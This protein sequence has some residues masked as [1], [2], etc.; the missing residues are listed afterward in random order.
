MR[1]GLKLW[2]NNEYYIQPAIDLYKRKLFDYIE[3]FVV[4]DSISYVEQWKELNIPFILHA[5][6]SMVGF[7][8]AVKE[9]ENSNFKLLNELERYREA[10][11]PQFI[12][13]HPGLDGDINET[14]R[15][16]NK[17][18][19][20]FHKIYNLALVENKPKIGLNGETCIA[21]MP[22]EIKR[23]LT[24]TDMRFCCDIGHAICA[25]NSAKIDQ[26]TFL[27]QFFKLNPLMYHLSDGNK[28]SEKDTH[29]NYGLGNFNI[30][31]I[32]KLLPHDSMI[33]IETEKATKNNLDDFEQ[34]VQYLLQIK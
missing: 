26:T 28:N 29:L 32:L 33:S 18:G 7:N 1:F 12:I 3:L 2:S 24:E 11:N 6:H 27:N 8:P 17:I 19:D 30:K 21:H 23:I 9:K 5:P 4:P 31:A 25:A 20:K 34:D 14:I 22:D 13:F 10:L 15:Q 16:F